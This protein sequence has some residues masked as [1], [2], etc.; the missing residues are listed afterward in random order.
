MK[1]VEE[2]EKL[3]AEE[4]KRR[5]ALIAKLKEENQVL[6]KTALKQSE[7]NVELMKKIKT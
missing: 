5:D 4:L 6:M 2:I 3:Y 1:S 7:K